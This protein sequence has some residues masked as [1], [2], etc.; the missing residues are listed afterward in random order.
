MSLQSPNDIVKNLTKIILTNNKKMIREDDLKHLSEGFEF[1]QIIGNVYKNLLKV[2]F[3]LISTKFFD[4]KYYILTSEGKDD[5]ISP[6]QY[7]SLALILALSKEIDENLN[8]S[9]L[10]E[11]FSEVW[12]LDIE[13]L[14]E[15]DYLRK[16]NV[17]GLDIVRV[18]PL[19]KAVM[20]NII[21]NL[22]LKNLLGAFKN[23]KLSP[24]I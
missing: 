4:Q 10:K 2:G 13:F 8:L 20:K 22:Q 15:T 17:E 19:G 3:E 12:T 5:K 9:D 24:E 21:N 14:I 7:G 11:I 23:D 1:D 16:I 18:T 6:S